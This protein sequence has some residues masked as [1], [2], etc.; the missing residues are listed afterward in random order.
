[1]VNNRGFA[2]VINILGASINLSASRF[3][4][5]LEGS[6]AALWARLD[7]THLGTSTFVLAPGA[8]A[9]I[10][11]QDPPASQFDQYVQIIP[12]L[13]VGSAAAELGW[14]LLNTAVGRLGAG[15]NLTDCVW[16]AVYNEL[17][18]STLGSLVDQ[19]RSCAFAAGPLLRSSG[20][21]LALA[22]LAAGLLVDNFFYNI[23][24]AEADG[25]LPNAIGFTVPASLPGGGTKSI[26]F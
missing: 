5:T 24:D 7:S 12:A 19:L 25:V 13:H 17:T 8:S 2:Q 1:M 15:V 6:A 20:A 3:S 18:A 22:E 11:I 16:S 26:P 21:R 9:D 4:D 10:V 14:A 23:V